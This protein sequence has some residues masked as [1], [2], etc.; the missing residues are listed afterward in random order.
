M[1]LTTHMLLTP[2]EAAAPQHTHTK[3][4]LR[5]LASEDTRP[6]D[7]IIGDGRIVN[8]DSDTRV[9]ALDRIL[10]KYK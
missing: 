10:C 2:S 4:S 8:I 9:R 7:L 6:R 3:P 1:L 5:K